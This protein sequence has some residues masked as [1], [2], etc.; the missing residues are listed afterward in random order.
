MLSRLLFATAACAAVA[1]ARPVRTVHLVPHTHD[2]TGWLKTVDQ[3][4]YGANGT[5]YVAGTQYIISTVVQALATD[6]SR[7]FTYVEQAFLARWW[8]EQNNATKATVRALV[9]EGRLQFSNAGWCMHDEA[10]PHWLD[11]VD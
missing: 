5:I 1:V 2:D 11:M 4:H 7:R 8:G 10:T 3:Y 6:P 9:K